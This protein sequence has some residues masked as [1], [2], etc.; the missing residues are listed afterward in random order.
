MLSG[1]A[2][3][4]VQR[5]IVDGLRRSQ[6]DVVT[7]RDAGMET[8]L[9]EA[10]LDHALKLQRVMLTNDTDFIAIANQYL[11]QGV[12]FAPV[13]YWPQSGRSPGENIR[14]ILAVAGRFQYAEIL[15]TL[16]YI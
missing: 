9:D 7:A 2:D 6:M 12:V 14:R 16:Q 1:F 8:A 11:A 4:H 15:S 10:L 5:G 13:F 3:V